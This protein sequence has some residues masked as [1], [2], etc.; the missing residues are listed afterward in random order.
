MC[1][2]VGI[3]GKEPVAPLLVKSLTRLEY[4]GYDS[5]GVAAMSDRGIELRKDVGDVTEVAK[6]L[7]LATTPGEIGIAHTRWATHGG[8][9]RENAHPH[10]S[11]D[12]NFAIVHNGIISNYHVLRTDLQR[13]G[14]H[15][16]SET[17]TEVL[18]HLLEETYLPGVS[19]EEA[20]IKA[21]HHL[22]SLASS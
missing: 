12:G 13:R 4:R 22:E 8:V 15:F 2:I 5:C 10:L 21:L 6:Q 19:V 1:G 14:H 16:S 18:A 9:S 20:F 17:D 11:C 3:I 7:D